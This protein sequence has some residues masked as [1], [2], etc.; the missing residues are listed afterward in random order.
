MKQIKKETFFGFVRRILILM[1][2][3]LNKAMSMTNFYGNVPWRASFIGNIL[4][5]LNMDVY[6]QSFGTA[7]WIESIL[8]ASFN[9]YIKH[10]NREKNGILVT[11]LFGNSAGLLVADE[12]I[13]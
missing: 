11:W 9:I 4:D 8:E 7:Q 13:Y 2:V 10:Q 1:D 3:L 5:L 12:L 6:I